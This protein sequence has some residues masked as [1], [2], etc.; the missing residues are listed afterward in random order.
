MIA[1][2]NTRFGLGDRLQVVEGR[3]GLP[4]IRIRGPRSQ[5][6]IALQGGHVASWRPDGHQEVMWQSSLCRFEVGKSIRGGIPICWP[7][8]GD[9][10]TQP[11]WPAHG[12]AR[13]S[14]FA[15]ER[16]FELGDGEV[17]VEL[18]LEIPEPTFAYTNHTAELRLLISMGDA[19]EVAMT[20]TNRGH[21]SMSCSA[22]LHS[23]LAVGDVEQVEIRGLDGLEYLDKPDGYA[24]K[25]QHGSPKIVEETDRIYLQSPQDAQRDCEV[26][27]PVLGRTLRI[28]KRGSRSTV[29]WNP[30]H[31]KALAMADFETPAFRQ[32]LC[33]EAANAAEDTVEILPGASHTLATMIGVSPL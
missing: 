17:G 9:H 15:I 2:L 30:W 24:R 5:G 18:K 22:A 16:S 20:T 19:L 21:D 14:T 3:G 23:Y 12:Y 4:V 26:D 10:P 7:W 8:F 13:T 25:R 33:V 11:D 28:A 31:A 6:E 29:L 1:D 32:M 27:D